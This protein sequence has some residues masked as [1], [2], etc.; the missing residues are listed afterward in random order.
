MSLR[1]TALVYMACFAAL[2]MGLYLVKYSVQNIQRSVAAARVELAQEKESL[3]L[4][5]AEWAYLNRPDRL[6]RLADKHLALVPLS[7]K[8]INEVSALPAAAQ[9][10][11]P[12]PSL[13]GVFQP[14][15]STGAAH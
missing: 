9:V 12:G 14:A 2:S 8:Q 6:N 10:E 1:I 3:H 5:N 7:S 4:L 11:R 13:D 15:N